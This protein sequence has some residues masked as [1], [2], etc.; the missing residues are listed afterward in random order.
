MNEL[1]LDDVAIRR[2]S[3]SDMANNVYL[4]T[5][6]KSGE[7]LLIDAADD[8]PAIEQ[9]IG[10][11]LGDAVNPR[12]IGIATTHQHWDHVRALAQAVAKYP[13]PT[14]AGTD[15]VEGIAEECSVRISTP[16]AHG[17]QLQLGDVVITAIHLRGHTPGS[18][19][20]ALT[21]SSG[22]EVI[23]SGDSL[24][25]GGIGRTTNPDDF[26]HLMTDVEGRIFNRYQDSTVILPGHGAETTL[27]A[28]RPH[29]ADWWA[30]GW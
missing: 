26:R 30:R 15:D 4:V 20:Y 6:R 12:L 25:P 27:G 21:D 13:V 9:L 22:Q 1:L 17:D 29:L 14:Y 16:L 11:A 8:M 19:A 3:V 28:E 18:M 7:Q 23:F 10:S 2:V 24:F 5:N